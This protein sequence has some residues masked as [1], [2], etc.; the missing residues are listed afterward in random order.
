[1]ELKRWAVRRTINRFLGPFLKNFGV[2]AADWNCF[3]AVL[4]TLN[5][6]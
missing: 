2:G 4:E 6:I 3:N 1:M 5:E